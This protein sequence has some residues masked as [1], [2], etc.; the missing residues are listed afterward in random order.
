MRFLGPAALIVLAVLFPASMTAAAAPAPVL[1]SPSDGRQFPPPFEGV[2]FV[3]NGEVDEPAGS[4]KIQI[5]DADGTFSNTGSFQHE[6]GVAEYVLEQVAPGGNRYRVTVPASEFES[7]GDTGELAFQAYRRLPAGTCPMVAN[8][9]TPDCFQESKTRS[10][11]II[12][13]A[14]YGNHEPNNTSANATPQNDIFNSDCAYLETATDVD[15]YRIN[16]ISRKNFDL[17]VTLDNSADTDRWKPLGPKRRESAD[18]SVSIYRATGM[19]KV[20]S[21]HVAVGKTRVLKT[22]I[23]PRTAY[24]I[25]FRHAGNGFASAKAATNMA[26]FFKINF[27]SAFS[28]AEGCV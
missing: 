19:R 27:P 3:V 15:W 21:K 2:T 23:A 18:M 4:L 1:V 16:G 24:L 10:F 14:G 22:R 17:R 25:A 6:S 5:T 26:Y 20:A 7:Y 8:T 9:T 13:P 12:D 28:D 11:G